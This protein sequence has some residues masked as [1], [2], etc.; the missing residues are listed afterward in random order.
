M[1]GNF[2]NKKGAKKKDIKKEDFRSP[3]VLGVNLV[4]DELIVFFDWNKHI[5]LSILV[6]IVAAL[7]VFEIHAGLNYWEEQE[8][9][10]QKSCALKQ[11][12]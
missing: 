3:E 10:E 9:E 7:F 6:F 5:F 2:L 11:T 12:N 8:S 4:K 1:F